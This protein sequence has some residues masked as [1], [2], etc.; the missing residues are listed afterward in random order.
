MKK[1]LIIDNYDSFTYT[2]AQYLQFL[3][4]DVK[5]IK[6][7][8][9]ISEIIEEWKPDKLV[10]SPGP[11]NPA[12]AGYC[13]ETVENY[14]TKLP[15]LGICLGMQIINEVFGGKTK[16]YKSPK[17]GKTSKITHN[18]KDIFKNIPTPF[19]AARYHS[20]MTDN[21]KDC[22]EITAT[23]EEDGIPMGIRHRKYPIFG[24]QFHPESFLTQYGY[25]LLNNFL[26]IS[27][28]KKIGL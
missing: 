23:A 20:L 10:I 13:M 21:I 11:K 16:Q 9:R 17:H 4:S 28:N 27:Y 18:A 5:V 24:L 6:H 15:I 1:I 3:H 26:N 14:K 2:I 7:D 8:E 12:N 22:I 19:L 25:E